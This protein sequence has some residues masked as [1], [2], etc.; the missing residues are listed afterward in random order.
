MKRLILALVLGVFSVGV[1]AALISRAGGAAYYDNVLDITW[2][3]DGSYALTSGYDTDVHMSWN[4]AQVFIGTVNASNL[5]GINTWRLPSMDVN[6]DAY[7]IFCSTSTEAE[8]RDTELGYMGF[9]NGITG[10]TPGQF[11]NVT[12]LYWSNT[13]YNASNTEWP[14]GRTC[15]VGP[16]G[17][18]AWREGFPVDSQNYVRKTYDGYGVWLVADGDVAPVPIPPAAWLFGS[19]LGLLG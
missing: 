6:G 9:I 10:D 15:N 18:C 12:N 11:T 3:A 8:C 7:L 13:D 16:S 5:L 17:L 14:D 19:A 4:D 2:L 1:Q